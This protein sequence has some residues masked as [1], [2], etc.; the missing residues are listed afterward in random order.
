MPV[1]TLEYTDETVIKCCDGIN[2]SLEHLFEFAYPI[3]QPS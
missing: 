2:G 1:S 3:R